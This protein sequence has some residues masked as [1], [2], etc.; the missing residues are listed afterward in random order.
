VTEAVAGIMAAEDEKECDEPYLEGLRLMLGQP[1]FAQR[2]RMLNIME[3]MEAKG[4]LSSM[5]AQRSSSGGVQVV[6]GEESQDEALRDLS[7]VFS[8][9]GVPRK[10]G[11]TVAVIGPTR[12]DY[13]RAI[14]TVGCVSGVLSDLLAGVCH[15]D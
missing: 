8:R 5:F 11:G 3:L 9:Y 6:I 4:W 14:S 7:L 12:M 15:S 10:V 13:R 2:D 1:E